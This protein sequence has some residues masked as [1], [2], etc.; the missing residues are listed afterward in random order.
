MWTHRENRRREITVGWH[1]EIE[2]RTTLLP[3]PLSLSFYSS[4][5]VST[6]MC[7]L[8]LC[9]YF[10]FSPFIC[11]FLCL[12][13]FIFILFSSSF[14]CICLSVLYMVCLSIFSHNL[15]GLYAFKGDRRRTQTCRYWQS[16]LLAYLYSSTL[17]PSGLYPALRAWFA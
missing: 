7:S 16:C 1:L 15:G 2:A 17:L 9:K 4:S 5:F 6:F 14:Q 13:S 11:L 8:L 3:L 12:S 10:C